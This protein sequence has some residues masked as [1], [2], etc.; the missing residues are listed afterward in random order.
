MQMSYRS[1]KPVLTSWP[2]NLE[3]YL[4]WSRLH[5]ISKE[6]CLGSP[7]RD[8]SVSWWHSYLGSLSSFLPILHIFVSI[9]LTLG[10]LVPI[11]VF[12]AG[13]MPL[14]LYSNHTHKILVS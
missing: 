2:S 1:F 10:E 13:R 4:Q 12:V 3:S 5:W 14:E 9:T 11:K 8:W 6:D 7:Y